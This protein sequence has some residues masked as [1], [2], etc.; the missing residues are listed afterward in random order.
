MARVHE[1]EADN[2]VLISIV[3][4]NIETMNKAKNI[5]GLLQNYELA[6]T[7]AAREIINQLREDISGSADFLSNIY[8]D[9]KYPDQS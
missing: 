4:R 5:L 6:I 8:H 7:P 3:E 1:L 9:G 2:I